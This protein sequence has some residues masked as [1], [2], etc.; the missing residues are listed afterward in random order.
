MSTEPKSFKD[1][2]MRGIFL[3]L[4]VFVITMGVE[5]LAVYHFSNQTKLIGDLILSF[6]ASITFLVVLKKPDKAINSS[7]DTSGTIAIRYKKFI[8]QLIVL[9]VTF[10]IF[11]S[12]VKLMISR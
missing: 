12:A 7:E 9:W 6:L 10:F 1:I 5:V 2:S 4:V 11:L 8:Q 3:A